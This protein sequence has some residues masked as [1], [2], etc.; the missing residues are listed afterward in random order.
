M[1]R[2]SGSENFCCLGLPVAPM[3]PPGP[4]EQCGQRSPKDPAAQASSFPP[5]HHQSLG[6]RPG[7]RRQS[8]SHQVR[9]GCLVSSVKG[10]QVR[11]PPGTWRFP[12]GCFPASPLAALGEKL[13]V[14]PEQ[15]SESRGRC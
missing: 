5:A 4:W 15:V 1:G 11:D 6:F 10:R 13:Q 9:N 3:L 2:V 14:C 12:R 8:P 7:E